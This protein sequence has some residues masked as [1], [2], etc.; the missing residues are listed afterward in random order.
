MPFLE[1]DDLVRRQKLLVIGL[2][3]GKGAVKVDHRLVDTLQRWGAAL[4]VSALLVLPAWKLVPA[5]A[6]VVALVVVLYRWM[7]DGRGGRLVAAGVA[8][9]A[10]AFTMAQLPVSP[11]RPLPFLL[12]V[13]AAA[14]AGWRATAPVSR[15]IDADRPFSYWWAVLKAEASAARP[16]PK[17]PTR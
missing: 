1:P 11:L 10:G 9:L 12:A 16:F 2:G 8:A 15:H 14:A 3:H 5:G 13:A 6:Y 4:A 7:A 17:E